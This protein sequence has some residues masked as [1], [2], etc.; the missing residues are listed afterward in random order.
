MKGEIWQKVN[1]SNE[2]G[3][4][5]SNNIKS[6]KIVPIDGL[7]FES[8]LKST[9]QHRLDRFADPNYSSC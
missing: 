8:K 4:E 2:S 6:F 7:E 1:I 9:N 3:Q 5:G